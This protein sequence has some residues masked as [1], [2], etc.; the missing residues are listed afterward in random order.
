MGHEQ[1][2]QV[3]VTTGPRYVPKA[4]RLFLA[5]FGMGVWSAKA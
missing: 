4:Q 5:T 2:D 3:A 1:L